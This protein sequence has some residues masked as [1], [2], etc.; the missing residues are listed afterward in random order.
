MER[1]LSHLHN[2][3][4]QRTS[5]ADQCK[6]TCYQWLLIDQQP[7]GASDALRQA[8]P[9]PSQRRNRDRALPSQCIDLLPFTIC[10]DNQQTRAESET[11]RIKWQTVLSRN[12]Q[13]IKLTKYCQLI[14]TITYS[15]IWTFK[16]RYTCSLSMI[17]HGAYKFYKARKCLFMSLLF[18]RIP[19]VESFW[20][21]YCMHLFV[22]W[23][24]NLLYVPAEQS[25]AVFIPG[26]CPCTINNCAYCIL[27]HD[28]STL[29]FLSVTK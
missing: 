7:R 13:L 5:R 24:L 19:V 1:S 4:R 22:A 6:D 18:K 25:L 28:V 23:H 26:V 11:Q 15:P 9:T 8:S 2:D 29:V 27:Q 20:H 17:E 16:I 14:L 12:T 3:Q 10:K 21:R